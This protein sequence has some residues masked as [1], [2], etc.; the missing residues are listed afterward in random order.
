MINNSLNVYKKPLKICGKNPLTGAYRD[1][2]CNT[3]I[4]DIGTHTVCAV[5]TNSFLNFS[6]SMGNDL[7]KDNPLYNFKGLKEG[8]NWCLCVSRWIEAYKENVAPPI[9]L[10]STHI[11][12]LEYISIEI[13]EKFDFKKL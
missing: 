9:I 4:D 6:K 13:L 5:V 2:C 11:K 8:D 12:T 7:T 10:E 1:G 3:G